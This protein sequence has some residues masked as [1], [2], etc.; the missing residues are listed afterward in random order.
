M[1]LCVG[2]KAETSIAF[3]RCQVLQ[4]IRQ[5][6]AR[7]QLIFRKRPQSPQEF[8]FGLSF[9]GSQVKEH[10]AIRNTSN[11][12][13]GKLPQPSFDVVGGKL[14][15]GDCDENCGWVGVWTRATADR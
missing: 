10:F 15:V 1:S 13:W 6:T 4:Q 7:W 3:M 14:I 2:G 12:G 11:N 8:V 9:D 5:T